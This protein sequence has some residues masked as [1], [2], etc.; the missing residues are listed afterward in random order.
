MTTAMIAIKSGFSRFFRLTLLTHRYAPFPSSAILPKAVRWNIYVA[1][2]VALEINFH[3]SNN[4]WEHQIPFTCVPAHVF[5]TIQPRLLHFSVPHLSHEGIYER[6][7]GLGRVDS[8]CRCS[9]LCPGT[10][11]DSY[12][13][14]QPENWTGGPFADTRVRPCGDSLAVHEM[15]PQY[16]DSVTVA[17]MSVLSRLPRPEV[18]ASTLRDKCQ[19]KY[20]IAWTNMWILP[21]YSAPANPLESQTGQHRNP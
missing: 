20:P 8:G 9:P 7:R 19:R 16:A 18:S 2:L 12:P 21:R 11:S 6:P 15:K 3:T 17:S 4:T 13:H 1:L 14:H 10:A 5:L